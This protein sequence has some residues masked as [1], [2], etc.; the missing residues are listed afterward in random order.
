MGRISIKNVFP[1]D[2]GAVGLRVV[3]IFN[4][5]I[6]FCQIVQGGLEIELTLSNNQCEFPS[7]VSESL[8]LVDQTCEVTQ[9]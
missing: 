6:T 5:M 1:L 4:G 2:S 7:P 9:P 3:T 8:T